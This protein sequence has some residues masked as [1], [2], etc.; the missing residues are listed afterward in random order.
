V[1]LEDPQAKR[2][3]YPT[4]EA[5]SLLY[6]LTMPWAHTG[7][8]QYARS[9]LANILFTLSLTQRLAGTAITANSLHP[10]LVASEFGS[11]NGVLGFFMQRFIA[12]RGISVEE[13]A[14][15]S[16]YAST[17]ADLTGVSGAYLV[18]CRA[19]E[20]AAPARQAAADQRLWEMS[21]GL[22]RAL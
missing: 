12:R 6:C 17:S 10:G 7:F 20:P 1:D 18:K 13:G 2:R 16:I 15:T 3:A 21:E 14:A 5:G 4:S 8:M 11:G 9:K 22:T 19:T